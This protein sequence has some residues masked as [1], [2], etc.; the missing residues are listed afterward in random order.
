MKKHGD[1][2]PVLAGIIVSCIFGFSFM[3]TAQALDVIDPM[4][5]LAFRFAIAALVLTVLRLLKIIKVDYRGKNLF[6]LFVL[7]FLEPGIYFIFET[8]GIKMTSASQGGMV[9]ATIPVVV[10]ILSV[11]ILKE[12]P[13]WLQLLS[14]FISVGGVFFIILMTGVAPAGGN[15]WGFFV[16]FGAVLSAGG[17]NILS[18]KLSESFTASEITY[19]MMWFAAIFFNVI[20]VGQ[21]IIKGNLSQYFQPLSTI[22]GLTA[23]IYLGILS[24][25]VAYFLLNYMLARLEVARAAVFSNLVTIIAIIG[26]VF[27]RG[28]AFLWYHWIGGALILLGVYGTNYFGAKRVAELAQNTQSL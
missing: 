24:S 15:V 7:A 22:K 5:L 3:F 20:A 8:L 21:G 25:I 9:I 6:W 23:L 12:R 1:L 2:L 19:L 10:T 4:L 13:T 26:G 17:F 27:F 28:D 16:L 18:R 14:I 11:V